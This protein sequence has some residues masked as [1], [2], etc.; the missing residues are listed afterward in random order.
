MK[1]NTIILLV[2]AIVA[3]ALVSLLVLSTLLWQAGV[4]DPLVKTHAIFRG[5]ARVTPVT[6]SCSGGTLT[7]VFVNGARGQITEVTAN[8]YACNPDS[9][10]VGERTTCTIPNAV[11]CEGIPF[12]GRYE[13]HVNVSVIFPT[14]EKRTS[15]GNVSGPAV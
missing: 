5:F 14:G 1:K 7:V 9:V 15:V 3:A 10:A 12:G 13:S 11:G 2:V 8:G 6:W 4:F